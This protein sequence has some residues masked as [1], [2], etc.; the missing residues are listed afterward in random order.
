ME[1]VGVAVKEHDRLSLRLA[2]IRYLDVARR[3]LQDAP[4]IDG[5]AGLLRLA[6]RRDRVDRE[7]NG[8]QQKQP[9]EDLPAAFHGLGLVT[10]REPELVGAGGH[11][12]DYELHVLVE[13]HAELLG[14]LEHL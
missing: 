2:R 3:Q 13:L 10:R 7:E 9:E 12:V 11:R 8:K 6:L 4:V 14:A 5:E 1:R